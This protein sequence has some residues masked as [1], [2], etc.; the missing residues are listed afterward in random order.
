MIA[1]AKKII[2][3]DLLKYGV[4]ICKEQRK[5]LVVSFSSLLVFLLLHTLY[6]HTYY[7]SQNDQ[8]SPSA[9][10]MRCRNYAFAPPA[11]YCSRAVQEPEV[12]SSGIQGSRQKQV[13][14]IARNQ[15]QE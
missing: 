10:F 11:L 1:V 12:V 6:D 5:C 15:D 9:S 4:G 2:F 8:G 3:S 14:G 7:G 13:S